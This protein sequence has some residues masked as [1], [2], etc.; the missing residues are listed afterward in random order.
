MVTSSR[1]RKDAKK[2]TSQTGSTKKVENMTL[3]ER[4]QN[5]QINIQ[6]MKTQFVA[7]SAQVTDQV[8]DAYKA[9][10]QILGKEIMSGEDRIEVGRIE[11]IK[12]KGLLKKHNIKHD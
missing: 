7:T 6:K 3:Q 5:I 8:N 4:K 9:A 2:K 10:L 1:K 12:L 11:I